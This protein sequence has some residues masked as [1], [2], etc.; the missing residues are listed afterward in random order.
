[1]TKKG[2]KKGPDSNASTQP[3]KPATSNPVNT[4]ECPRLTQAP[5]PSTMRSAVLILEPYMSSYALT[6]K[7]LALIRRSTAELYQPIRTAA[8]PQATKDAEQKNRQQKQ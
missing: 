2:E 4:S 7:E 6:K 3:P 5:A 1:M 8:C